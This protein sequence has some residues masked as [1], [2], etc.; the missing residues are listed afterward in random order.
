MRLKPFLG[1]AEHHKGLSTWYCYGL[2]AWISYNIDF[3]KEAKL[4]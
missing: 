2:D 1:L 3:K 4:I